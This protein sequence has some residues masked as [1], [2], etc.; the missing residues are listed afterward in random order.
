MNGQRLSLSLAVIIGLAAGPMNAAQAQG[1]FR[2][3]TGSICE[4]AKEAGVK[5][6]RRTLLYVDKQALSLSPDE[7]EWFGAVNQML[8]QTMTTAEPLDIVVLD[9]AKG[10]AKAH[11]STL[12]YP[13]IEERYHDRFAG[14]GI[15]GLLT[16]DLIDQLPD[17]K[18]EITVQMQDQVGP[19]YADAPQQRRQSKAEDIGKRHLLRALQSDAARFGGDLPTRVILY[20]DMIDNSDLVDLNAVLSGDDEQRLNSATSAIDDL[21]RLDFQGAMV[22]GFGTAA[23]LKNPVA[24]DAL[25]GFMQQVVYLSNGYPGDFSRELSVPAIRPESV[26]QYDM[27]VTV[28][29]RTFKGRMQLMKGDNGRL[30]DSFLDLGTDNRSA[31]FTSGRLICSQDNSCQLEGKLA[32]ALLFEDPEN[33]FLEGSQDTL[34]GHLG[35]RNDRLADSDN[36][37]LLPIEAEVRP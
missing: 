13:V 23:A 1:L 26:A 20:S 12:C 6:V 32:T 33:V 24:A 15:S 3:S 16:N 25:N 11:G 27:E 22:Y 5:P 30:T 2:S 28:E 17:L 19:G 14:S 21:P 7:Q 4:P 8:Q 34:S 31:H 35:F 10:T 29:E 36:P 18:K 37:A 9:S